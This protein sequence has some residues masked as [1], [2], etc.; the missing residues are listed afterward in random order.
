MKEFLD[1]R[2]GQL[3]ILGL[4]IS[5]LLSIAIFLTPPKKD[6]IVKETIEKV[7]VPKIHIKVNAPLQKRVLSFIKEVGI[8]YPDV[9]Y[10]QAL[11]ESA[12]FK[13]KHFTKKNNIFGMRKAMQRSTLG[14]GE[15]GEFVSFKSIEESIIDYKLYQ[16][17]FIHKIHSKQEYLNRLCTRYCKDLGY[18]RLI[19]SVIDSQNIK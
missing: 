12:H 19:L 17:T 2:E 3:T 7:S 11:I 9:V 14:D 13:S 1:S 6:K 16:M 5:I 10:A 4:A 18:E 15:V 8:K